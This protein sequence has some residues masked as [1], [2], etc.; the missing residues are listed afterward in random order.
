MYFNKIMK[1]NSGLL[2]RGGYYDLI[3]TKVKYITE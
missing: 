3:F 1:T 2:V